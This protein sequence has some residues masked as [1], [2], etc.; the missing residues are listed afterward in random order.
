[1][2][3]S[4]L[5]AVGYAPLSIDIRD[6]NNDGLP[7]V[8]TANQ[9]SDDISVLLGLGDRRFAPE[10]RIPFGGDPSAIALA[11][12]DGDG[13]LDMAVTSTYA[14][15]LVLLY[16][17]GD[18][19]FL[20][21][22]ELPVG[23]AP[24]SVDISDLNNDGRPDLV[25]ANRGSDDLTVFLAMSDGSFQEQ[26]PLSVGHQPFRVLLAEIDGD[27]F[28]DLLLANNGRRST[29]ILG[30]LSAYLGEG[31]GSF[32]FSK[33][34]GRGWDFS[35]VGADLDADE[36]L[37]AVMIH[38]G[39]QI[40]LYAGDD[41]GDFAFK[42]TAAGL[43]QEPYA[44]AAVD[45]DNDSHTDLVVANRQ[46]GDVSVLLGNSDWRFQFNGR[47]KTGGSYPTNLAAGDFNDDGL[48]DI[49]VSHW[50]S[51]DVAIL[52][53]R[54]DGRLT[55]Q[56]AFAT[57]G[58]PW[59]AVAADFDGDG[60]PD[61]AAAI[62]S[63]A[64]GL[65]LNDGQGRFG[66]QAHLEVGISPTRLTSSDFNADGFPDL[67]VIN[68]GSQDVSVL[69]GDG[70]GAF[71]PEIRLAVGAPLRDLVAGD[72]NRDGLEDLVFLAEYPG[73][74]NCGSGLVAVFDGQGDGTFGFP[75]CF[76]GGPNPFKVTTGDF[77]G[78][79]NLDLAMLEG[80]NYLPLTE[81][82]GYGD[83][84][85]APP[86][87]L[88]PTPIGIYKSADG[89]V[90]AD[91]QGDG[92]DDIAVVTYEGAQ[93][94]RYSGQVLIGGSNGLSTFL[95]SFGVGEAPGGM[96]T[97]DFNADGKPDLALANF[98]D[99]D[100]SIGLSRL[101]FVGPAFN[102][103]E[104]P[105]GDCPIQALTNDFNLDGRIDLA[106]ANRCSE[107]ITVLLNVGPFPDS[108]GDGIPDSD[109]PCTDPDGDGYGTPGLPASECPIDN[110]SQVVNPSQLDTDRDGIGDL[111]DNCPIDSNANQEDQDRDD[112][113]DACD[114]CT[115]TDR[116]SYGNPGFDTTTCA[117]DNCPYRP[118]PNQAD[119]DG[120]GQ[121]DL[122][123][124][125]TD[126]DQDGFGSPGYQAN[127]CSSDNC[128]D[129]TNPLQEDADS[130]GKGDPCDPCP[131]D[132]LD[133]WDRDGFCADQD[134]CPD[135]ANPGQEDADEDGFGDLC[136]NCPE[137]ANAGQEDS[138]G[139]GD[140]DACQPLL[141]IG[142]IREDGGQYLEVMAEATDP[143]GDLL[144]GTLSLTALEVIAIPNQGQRPP[145]CDIGYFPDGIAGEGIGYLIDVYGEALLFDLDRILRCDDRIPDYWM[146]AEPCEAN[147]EPYYFNYALY[148]DWLA[149]PATIC[150][151]ADPY[152]PGGWNMTVTGF[153]DS[154][155]RAVA[156]A[157]SPAV[158]QSFSYWLPPR[159]DISM[160]D[161]GMSYNLRLEV[162]DGSTTP[163]IDEAKFLY[164]GEATML[165]GTGLP[166]AVIAA[167][168]MFECAGPAGAVVTLDGSNSNGGG[169]GD[170][171]IFDWSAPGIVFDDPASPAP[172]ATF[173]I[174]VTPV[175]LTVSNALA[176]SSEW[177]DVTV[178]D[179]A[180]PLAACADPPPAECTGPAGATVGLTA[181]ATDLCSPVV[182]ISNDRTAGGA[183][184]S[185]LYPL[186]TTTVGF[187][188]TD[189]SGNA[190][191]CAA[192]VV[193]HDETAPAFTVAA[194]T[195]ELW[196]PNHR[197]AEVG[198]GWTLD[199][200]CDSAPQVALTMITSSEPDDAP[201]DG[202][203]ATSNDIGAWTQGT[204]QS[205]LML[206]AERSGNGPGRV[207]QISYAA[208]D[209]SG[210]TTPALAIVTVPHD[211][212]SGPEPLLMQ[213]R[214]NGA[215]DRAE[216]FWPALP[217]AIGY[218]VISVNRT[219]IVSTGDQT[220]FDA[221]RVLLRGG[222]VTYVTEGP[223]DLVPLPGEAIIY[224]I[225]PR[226]AQG[227][228]GYGT[229]KAPWPR[230]A[231]GCENGCP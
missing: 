133:D 35:I 134:T 48:V 164:Q 162:T 154:E 64:V 131:L 171:M 204:S 71:L 155:V 57:G 212:G 199:D 11:D 127:I 111:C 93:P 130:D 192:T 74:E 168:G 80:I 1:M 166:Q 185:G 96:A 145:S 121:G 88:N 21:D 20:R 49:A 223:G 56:P 62:D 225:Q 108:D 66:L 231:M 186:G 107:D 153:D 211:Q 139:D 202:D 51:P 73:I 85:F 218:D 45:I 94:V 151:R 92:K 229:A 173:P 104:V 172:S 16:G 165:I 13:T 175:L 176:E 149:L 114:T 47:P 128:P 142:S 9:G 8:V 137:A 198:I 42:G 210:N 106:V 209:A 15:E 123:D 101:P 33:E 158:E 12:L 156:F 135:L 228:A 215:P 3:D 189:A 87:R 75:R 191:S 207:Y 136:D 230:V 157:T 195:E 55:T 119:A 77:N 82:P 53:A 68:S 102:H 86:K 84:A 39:G 76:I 177:I 81:M 95:S 99:D 112:A 190:A 100:L 122:C 90:V 197:M 160:L 201:G 60:A 46:S 43:G 227:G 22:D 118:N 174:G 6:L 179:T 26:P 159:S 221:A 31:D 220:T 79:G 152:E 44:A 32:A 194:D 63:T 61:I 38:P 222:N 219:R 54:D 170:P 140:G 97:G 18:G 124:S 138:N 129:V 181:T 58:V 4:P 36:H 206:R 7:D 50:G 180:P 143:D 37:D 40:Y 91:F 23:D 167:L 117:I 196:P 115:D 27:G 203:G 17:N 146:A 110:C 125:C 105:I 141:V 78:D 10:I 70:A 67:A 216:L 184:A 19:T 150:V 116:D 213:L 193:V 144:S 120:D 224:F 214:T 161:P 226:T 30:A 126:L 147:P 69:C 59:S 113:G 217:E 183:D 14:D 5:Q 187:T 188:A 132:H 25:V 109:D 163:M 169:L 178:N 52:L 208:T 200:L 28:I 65:F 205:S 41:G 29:S 148:L 182:A 98:Q 24:A 2:F 83:G 72:F 34:I 89:F 103:Y